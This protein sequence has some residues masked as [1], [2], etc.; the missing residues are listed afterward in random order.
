MI[1]LL[2][3]LL[4][5]AQERVD[6]ETFAN[7]HQLSSVNSRAQ[8]LRHISYDY[9]TYR[10]GL[11]E[12]LQSPRIQTELS[13]PKDKCRLFDGYL[14]DKKKRRSAY[15]SKFEWHLRKTPKRQLQ[16]AGEF[17]SKLNLEFDTKA[18]KELSAQQTER[19]KQLFFWELIWRYG[20]TAIVLDEHMAKWLRLDPAQRA[21]ILD[22]GKKFKQSTLRQLRDLHVLIRNEFEKEL[23]TGTKKRIHKILGENSFKKGWGVESAEI[24]AHRNAWRLS[25]KDLKRAGLAPTKCTIRTQFSPTLEISVIQKDNLLDVML[26][27]GFREQL[28][29]TKE[30]KAKLA[31]LQKRHN[32]EREELH[33]S[34][35]SIARGERKP[36]EK[37]FYRDSKALTEK[38]NK[39]VNERLFLPH[40]LSQFENVYYT[41]QLRKNGFVRLLLDPSNGNDFPARI[42]IS[43][44]EKQGIRDTQVAVA[45]KIIAKRDAIQS[46]YL[47]SIYKCLGKE[48]QVSL[49]K[50]LGSKPKQEPFPDLTTFLQQIDYAVKLHASSKLNR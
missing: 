16:A 39:L 15:L 45:K 27:P 6:A 21:E 10:G 36:F 2:L 9:I 14:V 33:R 5:V 47:E 37:K 46:E 26:E 23:S 22:L 11:L 3:S 49:K 25:A 18:L 35:Y 48:R 8:Q 43:D 40:Q 13:L 17:L 20:I 24:L 32:E 7:R 34:F 29:F 4:I 44:E 50:L 30:Q 19:L 31:E 28:E 42:K 38:Y 1:V 41:N 12:M